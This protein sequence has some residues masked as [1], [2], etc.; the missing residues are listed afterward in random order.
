MPI[1]ARYLQVLPWYIAHELYF[2]KWNV[3]E[4]VSPIFNVCGVF[5]PEYRGG[6]MDGY[7]PGFRLAA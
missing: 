6:G 3:Q 7:V 1:Q 4:M 2:N 5:E